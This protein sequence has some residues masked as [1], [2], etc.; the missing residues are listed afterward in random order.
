MNALERIQN[1]LVSPSHKRPIVALV[2]GATCAPCRTLKPKLQALT[3]RHSTSLCLVKAE[4]DMDVVRELKVRAV[5]TV[6]VFNRGQEVLRF[7]GDKSED[8]LYRALARVGAFQ[9][10]LPNV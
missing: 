7:T 9:Q 3:E 4:D 8:D 2:W 1:L 5:P 6:L 10:P